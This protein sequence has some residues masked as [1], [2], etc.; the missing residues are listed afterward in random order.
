M[1]EDADGLRRNPLIGR[2]HRTFATY[3]HAV[4]EYWKKPLGNE[5]AP[6]TALVQRACGRGVQSVG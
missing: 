2:C 3:E 5:M 1:R 4:V 6:A